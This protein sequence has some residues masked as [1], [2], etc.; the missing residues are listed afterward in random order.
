MKRAR[1]L[2]AAAGCICLWTYCAAWAAPV[3]P[4][5]VLDFSTG[6]SVDHGS[7]MS[8][9]RFCDRENIMSDSLHFGRLRLME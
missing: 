3:K 4:L 2:C 9:T 6:E 1:G 5:T 8:F 7:G